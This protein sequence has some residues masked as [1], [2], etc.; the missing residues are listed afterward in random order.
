MHNRRKGFSL[1]ELLIYMALLAIIMVVI[2]AIFISVGS[3]N[4]RNQVQSE[5]NSNLRFAVEKIEDDLRAATAVTTPG[6]SL[7]QST[8]SYFSGATGTLTFSSNVTAGGFILAAVS[9]YNGNGPCYG[10]SASDTLSNVYTLAVSSSPNNIGG[11]MGIY[12]AKNIV[13]GPD[14]MT[15]SGSCTSSQSEFSIY[16]YSGIDTVSPFDVR[17][18]SSSNAAGTSISTGSSTTNNANELLFSEGFDQLN[19]PTSSL[20]TVSPGWTKRQAPTGRGNTTA[21]LSADQVVSSI[22]TYSN[23]FGGLPSGDNR[24]AQIATFKAS[25]IGGGATSNTLTLTTASG[26]ISYCVVSSTLRRQSGGGACTAS[27]DA[28]TDS[29]VLVSTSTFTLFQN[30]NSTLGKTAVSIQIDIAMSYN[31][32]GPD[33]QYSEEKITTTALRNL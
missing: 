4:T 17:N 23:T 16:E 5:V 30:T 1:L 13:A 31:G 19:G 11:A 33:E 25:T 28:I 6:I 21:A 20:W 32:T 8:S 18:A 14:S 9:D 3:G 27:S 12:Y 10:L 2:V 24:I 7:V 15:F 26:T 29:T 22:G